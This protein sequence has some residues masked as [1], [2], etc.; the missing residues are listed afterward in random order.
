MIS[1]YQKIVRYTGMKHE[2]KF[3]RMWFKTKGYV[4]PDSYRERLDP[5]SPFDPSLLRYIEGLNDPIRILDG[6]AGP[7]TSLGKIWPGHTLDI[8]AVD[9]LAEA[10]NKIIDAYDIK[11]PLRT[12]KCAGEELSAKFAHQ[13]FD[14]VYSRNAIDHA[15][16]P[17]DCIR[18]MIK[19]LKSGKT[20]LLIHE[21]NEGIKEEYVGLHQWNFTI[22]QGNF[23]IIDSVNNRCNVTEELIGQAKVIANVEKGYVIV[24]I[25]KH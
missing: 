22:E 7:L 12:Q 11:P 17:L 14:F 25:M 4:W 16:H 21:E 13:Q 20:A 24:Q 23:V 8:T 2:L 15:A 5:N 1:L 6:G 18:E 3:W 9:P 19:V 10:Y